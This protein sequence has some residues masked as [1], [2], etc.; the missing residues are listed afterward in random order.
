MSESEIRKILLRVCGD[1]DRRGQALVKQALR[2]TLPTMLSMGVAVSGGC[3]DED[4]SEPGPLYAAPVAEASVTTDGGLVDGGQPLYM[5]PEA[6]MGEPV[7]AYMGPP[8]EVDMGEAMGA[9]MAPPPEL[10]AGPAAPAYMGP[11]PA[12]DAGAD[13]D[14]GEMNALY[15]APPP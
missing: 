15:A 1:L 2:A 7:A 14:L 11:P 6:D 12:L 13:P 10:D 3:D 8:P 9:Y 5:A 4:D